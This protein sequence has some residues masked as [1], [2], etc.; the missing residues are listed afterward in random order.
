MNGAEI[1]DL[2]IKSLREP[3]S[4]EDE[5]R[6]EIWLRANPT[7][8]AQWDDEQRLNQLLNDLPSVQLSSNFTS[9]VLR[10]I[11]NEPRSKGTSTWFTLF[12]AAKR[13]WLRP[14]AAG[15]GVALVVLVVYRQQTHWQR[16]EWV[17]SLKLASG[18]ATA[19]QANPVGAT[20]TVELLEDFDAIR[21]LSTVTSEPD[22]T[23]LAVL[24]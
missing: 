4:P 24:E 21:R 11:Q 19:L 14:L 12:L 20:P 3:L 18:V 23:L 9:L 7:H 13:D 10:T 5:K 6:L 22:L 15:V 17:E 1:N 2:A 16:V 8:A